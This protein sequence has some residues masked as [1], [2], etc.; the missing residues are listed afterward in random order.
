M[1]LIEDLI[2]EKSIGSYQEELNNELLSFTD[3]IVVDI[4]S[5]DKLCITDEGEDIKDIC[6]T[7][8]FMLLGWGFTSFSLSIE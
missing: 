7:I 8:C 3:D 6:S 2:K 1:I 5:Q 4:L